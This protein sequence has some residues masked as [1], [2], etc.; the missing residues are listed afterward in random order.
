M[1]HLIYMSYMYILTFD[2]KELEHNCLIKYERCTDILTV[3]FTNVI[4]ILTSICIMGLD[5]LAKSYALIPARLKS[6]LD[7]SQ[8]R[9]SRRQESQ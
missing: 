5:V 1:V 4:P 3:M 6:A 7:G 9:T 2:M 8:G